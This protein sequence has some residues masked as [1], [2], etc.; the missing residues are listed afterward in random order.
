[1]LSL[2][3]TIN[4]LCQENKASTAPRCKGDCRGKRLG[5]PT[6]DVIS[7]EGRE[8][9][10]RDLYGSEGPEHNKYEGKSSRNTIHCKIHFYCF[11]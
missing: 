1:M 3:E 6:L 2:G 4:V 9:R 10:G 11:S 5:H 7:P 8:G